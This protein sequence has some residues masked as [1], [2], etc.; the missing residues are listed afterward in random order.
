MTTAVAS[1]T[2]SKMALIGRDV[3]DVHTTLHNIYIYFPPILI[4]FTFL[5]TLS[6]SLH[7][8]RDCPNNTVMRKL[9]SNSAISD[10][11]S[12]KNAAPTSDIRQHCCNV[13]YP[14]DITL[15]LFLP[16]NQNASLRYLF[17]DFTNA[18]KFEY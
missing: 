3:C 16:A 13:A 14:V 8:V 15:L 7:S 4:F 18:I 11:I 10:T 9:C 1:R 12:V 6:L 2:A 5:T 17:N